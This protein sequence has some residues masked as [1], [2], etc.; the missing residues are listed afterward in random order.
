M[1]I[2]TFVPKDRLIRQ[3]RGRIRIP[4]GIT[5]EDFL[6]ITR[7]LRQI[8]QDI[9]NEITTLRGAACQEDDRPKELHIRLNESDKPFPLPIFAGWV[10]SDDV[11]DRRQDWNHDIRAS[12]VS[13]MIF[14]L[15]FTVKPFA[16]P[17][18]PTATSGLV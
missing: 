13:A 17:I 1:A 16:M 14:I 3:Q 4:G 8:L 9:D 15:R 2:S 10:E 6:E 5:P 11:R 12:S 18:N 7:I